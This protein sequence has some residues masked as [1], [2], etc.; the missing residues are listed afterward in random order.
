MTNLTQ[1]SDLLG[2]TLSKI[3]NSRDELIFT[4]NEGTQCK[5]HHEQDCCEGVSIEGIDGDLKDLI[6][7]PLTQAEEVS[8]EDYPAPE[9]ADSYTWTFY[10]MATVKGY[11]TIRWLG[12]SNGYYS[13]SVDFTVL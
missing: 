6:G 4:L 7:N 9:H 5:L 8:N 3:D 2:K 12:Q 11:V 13:E 10:K 1:F